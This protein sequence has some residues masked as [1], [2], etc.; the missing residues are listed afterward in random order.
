MSDAKH[1]HGYKALFSEPKMVEDLLRGFVPG[2]W[3]ER[4]DFSSL[5]KA[6]GHFISE[7]LLGREDDVIWRV[8]IREGGWLYIYL[9]LEFQSSPDRW[10][11]L[12][13]M[14]YVGLL[15]QDLIKQKKIG[16][17]ETLPPVVPVVLYNGEA[18]WTAPTELEELITHVE[19]LQA[20]RPKC[21]YLLLEEQKLA[22]DE[23]ESMRNLAAALFRLEQSRT[24]QDIKVVL[25]S[26]VEWLSEPEQASLRRAFL[27]WIRQALLPARLK[28]VPVPEVAELSE[29]RDML[30]ERVIEWTKQW[31]QEGEAKGKRAMLKLVERRFGELTPEQR[32][33]VEAADLEE[34]A[35][36]LLE[37]QSLDELLAP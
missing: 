2:E 1:D 34:L 24:A 13:I 6:S 35:D 19:G 33:R 25:E 18:P 29:V 12:R 3:V 11:A 21:R 37:A 32:E 26:L 31:K 5:E 9:L 20:Y 36:R 23:L 27:S 17:G 4:L 30:Q 15:W 14:V 8:R 16:S 28:G 10:M 7:E 22:S